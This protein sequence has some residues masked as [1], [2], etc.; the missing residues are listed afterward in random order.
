MSSTHATRGREGELIFAY[1]YEKAKGKKPRQ[2]GCWLKSMTSA[3]MKGGVHG[4]APGPTS[5]ARPGAGRPPSRLGGP[6]GSSANERYARPRTIRAWRSS[7]DRAPSSLGRVQTPTL[8]LIG[9]PR[10]GRSKAFVPEP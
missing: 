9:A 6:T 5:F 3:A 4:A 7:F 2:P 1:L 10:G 8:A